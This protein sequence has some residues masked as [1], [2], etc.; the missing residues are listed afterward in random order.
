[1]GIAQ[2]IREVG[3]L[4]RVVGSVIKNGFGYLIDNI[5]YGK[6]KIGSSHSNAARVRIMMEELGPTFVKLGQLLSL[7]RDLVPEE[8]CDEF[9]KLQDSVAEFPF[10]KVREIVERELKRPLEDIFAEFH[11]KPIAAA[12]IGQVHKARLRN[13]EWVVVKVQR[14]NIKKII[15]SDIDIMY[16]VAN[17]FE[18]HNP[19]VK[20]WHLPEIV[21][22]FDKYT[23]EELSYVVEANNITKFYKNFKE[24]ENV[25]IPKVYW[26][27]TT[28][29]VLCMSYIEGIKIND[30]K[31]F[32]KLGLTRKDVALMGANN[33]F[34]QVFDFGLF[35]ADPH[36]ANIYITKKG[37]IALLDFGIVGKLTSES[38]EKLLDLFINL[39]KKDS[40]GVCES[41]ISL[42]VLKRDVNLDN[43]K[44]DMS[45]KMG[46][47]YDVPLSDINL[48]DLLN[49]SINLALD[50]KIDIPVDLVLLA[51]AIVTIESVGSNLDPNFNLIEISQPYIDRVIRER[52]NPVNITKNFLKDMWAF[53]S[54][55][56][57]L[58]RQ[59]SEIL[60][61]L[62]GGDLTVRFKHEDLTD[63]QH[64][65][66]RSSNQIANGVLISALII[67][68][69][70]VWHSER[71]LWAASFAFVMAGILSL[72]LIYSMIKEKHSIK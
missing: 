68:G 60:E 62:R 32:G 58:P 25:V 14:P 26:D 23:H 64:E 20:R 22:E 69:S 47:Y 8:Y 28:K 48:G 71:A 70:L 33:F 51:K 52:T 11:K 39:V 3:R 6:G 4:N 21:K 67:G 15:E 35:H 1:M 42:G 18:S 56:K 16:H 36:P 9:K 24:N 45:S 30:F 57:K 38:R 44:E 49:D 31:E 27:Y 13:K 63:I 59:T 40:E 46:R 10:D 19:K 65:I 61:R 53:R 5:K 34:E 37:K 2:N 41:F 55:F 29:K 54:A 12:S 72:I 50:Y 17:L 66:A 43:F 7:R